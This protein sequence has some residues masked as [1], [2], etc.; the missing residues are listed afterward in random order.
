MDGGTH[1]GSVEI[2]RDMCV[3][4][5][6]DMR[7]DMRTD[8]RMDMRTDMRTDMEYGCER[9]LFALQACRVDMRMDARIGVC[10]RH[11]WQAWTHER[12]DFF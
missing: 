3:D 1:K 12:K 4:M 11:A 10:G 8:M 5:R 6:T 2:Q 7:M 9:G